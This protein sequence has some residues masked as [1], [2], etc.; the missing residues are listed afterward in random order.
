MNTRCTQ[1]LAAMLLLGFM[2]FGTTY[3]QPPTFSSFEY[4]QASNSVFLE[5]LNSTNAFYEMQASTN[6]MSGLWG[7][8]GVWKNVLGTNLTN[9]VVLPADG[10]P[11]GF[12]RLR[13]RSNSPQVSYFSGIALR[14]NT[15]L[16]AAEWPAGNHYDQLLVW[17]QNTSSY[18]VYIFS[19]RF[20]WSGRTD[21]TN[22]Q[23]FY[24]LPAN[25]DIPAEFSSYAYVKD[26]R[27]ISPGGLPG[28][29][30]SSGGPWRS[31]GGPRG[32]LGGSD[33]IWALK[34][35]AF[36]RS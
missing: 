7:Q 13:S 19:V 16:P 24:Y 10:H 25:E 35:F 32:V 1:G 17:D 12:F 8:E 26:W 20:T 18:S 29:W 5:W 28:L 21:I 2:G 11:N 15:N 9:S 31:L 33:S 14:A 34:H 30:G 36:R 23:S 3:A 22:N 4:N 27:L 6:L